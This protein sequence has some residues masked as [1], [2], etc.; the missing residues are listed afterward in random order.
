MTLDDVRYELE[1]LVVAWRRHPTA[2]AHRDEHVSQTA[3]DKCAD[4]VAQLLARLRNGTKAVR[5][6]PLDGY[7]LSAILN[8]LNSYEPDR[9]VLYGRLY[10]QVDG[11]WVETNDIGEDDDSDGT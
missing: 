2:Y 5:Q 10:R 9:M 7:R 4:D 8:E 6:D 1:Q 3:M 11:A